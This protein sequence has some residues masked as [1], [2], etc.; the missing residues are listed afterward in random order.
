MKFQVEMW[1]FGGKGKI[2]E[3]EVPFNELTGE[4]EEDLEL[5]FKYGQNDFQPVEGCRSVSADDVIQ[6]KV[7]AEIQ[8][9]KV[10]FCGFVN[11]ENHVFYHDYIMSVMRS[12]EISKGR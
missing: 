4:V 8:L 1:A 10:G 9:W 6:I 2:R 5:V 11:L 7:D 12:E 3:V